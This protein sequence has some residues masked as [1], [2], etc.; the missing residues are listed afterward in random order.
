MMCNQHYMLIHT[1]R[2]TSKSRFDMVTIRLKSESTLKPLFTLGVNV[3]QC[4]RTFDCLRFKFQQVHWNGIP[5]HFYQNCWRWGRLCITFVFRPVPFSNVRVSENRNNQ[6]SEHVDGRLNKETSVNQR[7]QQLQHLWSFPVMESLCGRFEFY[8]DACVKTINGSVYDLFLSNFILWRI[9]TNVLLTP[10]IWLLWL[11]FL[12][13]W[14]KNFWT[15]YHLRSIT[16]KGD[17]NWWLLRKKTSKLLNYCG[18]H[19]SN[20]VALFWITRCYGTHCHGNAR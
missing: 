4:F 6:I 9:S 2:P 19:H 15:I 17:Q 7:I 8:A 1:D 5:P 13:C 10:D 12:F 16:R 20:S 3:I 11:N 18:T 14:H